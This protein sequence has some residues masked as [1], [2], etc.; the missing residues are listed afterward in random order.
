MGQPGSDTSYYRW[1]A[2][3]FVKMA[4]LQVVHTDQMHFLSTQA[5]PCKS[6]V[7]CTRAEGIMQCPCLYLAGSA[8]V[9]CIFCCCQYDGLASMPLHWQQGNTA[10]RKQV[11]ASGRS[12]HPQWCI[13]ALD[14]YDVSEL[15]WPPEH[16]LHQ[17][18]VRILAENN[19]HEVTYSV[20]NIPVGSDTCCKA[21]RHSAAGFAMRA[22]ACRCACW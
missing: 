12:P 3:Y 9:W 1:C 6:I 22:N 8:C 4:C 11:A 5:S 14:G 2:P 18:A 15:G 19:P 20:P 17:Q 16:P 21:G 10:A 13:V 7:Q